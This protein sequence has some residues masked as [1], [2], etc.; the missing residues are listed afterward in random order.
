MASSS[1]LNVSDGFLLLLFLSSFALKKVDG[2]FFGDL[3]R[4]LRFG[5]CFLLLL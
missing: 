3:S 4:G 1:E 2:L 5:R